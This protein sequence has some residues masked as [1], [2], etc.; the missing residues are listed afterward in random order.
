L[1]AIP[2]RATASLMTRMYSGRWKEGLPA[3]DALREAQLWVL[4]HGD[5]VGAFDEPPPG[6][7]RTPPR[8]WAAFAFAG[9]WR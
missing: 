1:W 7:K 4:N 6:T 9:D 5:K 8:Y 2:D 3:A